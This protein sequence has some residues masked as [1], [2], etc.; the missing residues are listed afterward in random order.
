[1]K[2]IVDITEEKAL[3]LAGDASEMVLPVDFSPLDRYKEELFSALLDSETGALLVSI[4]N[5]DDEGVYKKVLA[6]IR[7]KIKGI[8]RIRID[9]AAEYSKPIREFESRIKS[10][11]SEINY[12]I[13]IPLDLAIKEYDQ[14]RID[15]RMELVAGIVGKLSELL[16]DDVTEG[17]ERKEQYKNRSMSD[18]DVEEDLRQ[19]YQGIMLRY[20]QRQKDVK[21]IRQ[22]AELESY[23]RGLGVPLNAAAYMRMMD[24]V[25][26]GDIMLA[27]EADAE[28]QKIREAEYARRV[29]A[30]AEAEAMA[31]AEADMREKA[32]AAAEEIAAERIREER[33]L[34]EQARRDADAAK[35][36][37]DARIAAEK[38][39]AQ[40]AL[41]VAAQTAAQFDRYIPVETIED[42]PEYTWMFRVKTTVAKKDALKRYMDDMEIFYEA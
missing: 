16:P 29:K 6:D 34:A 12:S 24:T 25:D 1:M 28:A 7:K 5:L 40:E 39:M 2:E 22:R 8:D 3:V 41:E 11:A 9:K 36:A 4:E 14:K 15:R 31:K 30:Q 38:E 18:K 19:Q 32:R 33:A 20:E 37:A 21:L 35:E 42:E 23:R 13:V 17:I 10:A 27:I 26:V